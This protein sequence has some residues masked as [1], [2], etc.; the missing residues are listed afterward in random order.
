MTLREVEDALKECILKDRTDEQIYV[1]MKILAEA[2]CTKHKFGLSARDVE[3]VSHALATDLYLRVAEG[4]LE[5]DFWQAYINRVLC[6][7]YVQR[8]RNSHFSEIFELE[9]N[10]ELEKSIYN[11]CAS[12]GISAANDVNRRQNVEY[13]QAIKG[14]IY[15][16]TKQSRFPPDTKDGLALYTSVCLSF[17]YGK[18]TYFR[19]KPELRPFVHILMR[20]VLGDII[21]SGFAE[22][23]AET[24]VLNSEWTRASFDDYRRTF[25]DTGREP[26]RM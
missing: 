3:E 9:D 14:V 4:K 1:Y 7:S 20:Q 8:Q 22:D 6:A 21:A 13:L 16:C 24:N 19:L 11:V 15:N 26:Y 12:S 25:L 17:Y 18:E 5:V 2:G 23:S 10:P